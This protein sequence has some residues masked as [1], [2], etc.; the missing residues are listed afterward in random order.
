MKSGVTHQGFS[1]GGERKISERKLKILSAQPLSNPN[2][3][4]YLAERAIPL[5]IA[6]AYYS[7]VLFRNYCCPLKL[8]LSK[9][10]GQDSSLGIQPF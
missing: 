1:F 10:L 7:E 5:S 6:N 2:L 4:C 9:K 3:L 8:F